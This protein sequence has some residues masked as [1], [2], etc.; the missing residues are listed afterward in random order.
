MSTGRARSLLDVPVTARQISYWLTAGMLHPEAGRPGRGRPLLW[1]DEE[2]SIICLAGHLI[3]DASL[4]PERALQVSRRVAAGA[5]R[6]ELA[7]GLTLAIS[8]NYPRPRGPSRRE[9]ALTVSDSENH[10]SG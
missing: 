5:V 3:Q 8:P 4:T 9:S 7:A 1:T 2:W 10:C 6:V